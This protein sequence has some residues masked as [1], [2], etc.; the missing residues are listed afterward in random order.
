[1]RMEVSSIWITVQQVMHAI[2]GLAAEF[3]RSLAPVRDLI[4]DKCGQP[5]LIAAYVALGVI[6]L[7][8]VHRLLK[9]TFAILKYL[10]I[11]SVGLAFLGTLVLPFSFTFL[12][13]ITVALC[14]L[15]LLI[16]A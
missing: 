16:K 11:P 15:V 3:V 13:P 10:V 5:G 1:M 6:G 9:I 12:L 7:V 8:V 2:V 14:S 4:V